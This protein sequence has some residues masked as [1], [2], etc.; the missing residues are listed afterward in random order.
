[1]FH[2]PMPRLFPS[3]FLSLLL[4][5][6]PVDSSII[7]SPFLSDIL[8][9]CLLLFLTSL[10]PLPLLHLHSPKLISVFSSFHI[11]YHFLMPLWPPLILVPHPPHSTLTPSYTRPHPPHS[12]FPS[13]H[14]IT[15][16]IHPLHI[17]VLPP[18]GD[19]FT[20][21]LSCGAESSDVANPVWCMLFNDA[22]CTCNITQS[23]N[24]TTDG[25]SLQWNVP[26]SKVVIY[27]G[28]LIGCF[29][30]ERLVAVVLTSD[31][32]VHACAYVRFLYACTY[33]HTYV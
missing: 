32:G 5:R 9:H 8:S 18:A 13:S 4:F 33:V 22:N 15:S 23:V 26:R 31:P 24:V 20:V 10:L 21:S 30:E 11:C 25:L 1:M 16:I 27:D 19:G 12:T 6:L 2:D 3:L 29:E 28:T 17:P 14:P 7:P